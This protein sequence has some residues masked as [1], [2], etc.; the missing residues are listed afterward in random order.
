MVGDKLGAD[1]TRT[2]VG[3]SVERINTMFVGIVTEVDLAKQEYDVQPILNKYDPVQGVD[4]ECAILF[5]CPMLLQKSAGFYVRFPYEVNDVVYVGVNKES[6]DEALVGNTPRNNRVAG[7]AKFREI[8]G[9]ILGGLMCEQEEALSGEDLLNFTVRNR[10]N[11]DKVVVKANGGLELK[12]G[13]RVIIDSPVTDITGDVNINGNTNIKGNTI[14]ESN[15]TGNS[16]LTISGAGNIGTVTSGSG[17]SLDNHTHKY[18]PGG[19]K[20]TDTAKPGGA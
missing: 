11:G 2:L 3:N 7:V 4:V 20:P 14:V 12:T 19:G 13:T 6:I 8:D 10:K 17:V 5:R 15:I 16:N 9:V 18:Y 1:A